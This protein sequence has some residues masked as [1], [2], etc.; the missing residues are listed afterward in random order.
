MAA[1]AGSV[2]SIG[3]HAIYTCCAVWPFLK[4]CSTPFLP[5]N[6]CAPRVYHSR[7]LSA[8]ERGAAAAA[9]PSAAAAAPAHRWLRLANSE[10]S[11]ARVL[12]SSSKTSVEPGCM[13]R[14]GI[15]GQVATAMQA[16]RHAS[17]PSML[18]LHGIF[19]GSRPAPCH[20]STSHNF[21]RSFFQLPFMFSPLS[22][23]CVL[24]C[25]A[26]LSCICRCAAA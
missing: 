2:G 8:P 18:S 5:Q 14:C 12:R 11:A 17:V 21:D 7:R 25:P 24:L 9:S 3:S 10:R 26:L 23:C 13:A 15:S 22:S 19:V 20:G 16:G 4:V 6:C 1:A